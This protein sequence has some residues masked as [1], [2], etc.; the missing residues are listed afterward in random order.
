[1][2]TRAQ[3][4]P[5]R[6]CSFWH[7]NASCSSSV[8]LSQSLVRSRRCPRHAELNRHSNREVPIRGRRTTAQPVRRRCAFGEAGRPGSPI[9]THRALSQAPPVLRQALCDSVRASREGREHPRSRKRD[10]ADNTHAGQKEVSPVRLPI[11]LV[12]RTSSAPARGVLN[13]SGRTSSPVRV[14]GWCCLQTSCGH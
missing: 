4:W 11:L 2:Q 12:A 6:S 3:V 5:L 14:V 1:V 10:Q 13:L 7:M 8:M 9:R